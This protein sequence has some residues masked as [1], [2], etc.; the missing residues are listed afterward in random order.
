M[1]DCFGYYAI[2]VV[3][4]VDVFGDAARL[5]W[6]G[7]DFGKFQITNSSEGS[8]GQTV[9]SLGR[10]SRLS[11]KEPGEGKH[12]KASRDRGIRTFAIKPCHIGIIN[13]LRPQKPTVFG[14]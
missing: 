4:L 10:R 3:E 8:G 5:D 12:G 1:K 7:L 9:E 13:P 11:W 14:S 2:R 6:G